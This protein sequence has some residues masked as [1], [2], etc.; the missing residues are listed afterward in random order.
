MVIT[1][2]PNCTF[3]VIP[4]NDIKASMIPDCTQANVADPEPPLHFILASWTAL[5]EW[6]RVYRRGGICA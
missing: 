2:G 4:K 6:L 3:F 5:G 1:G